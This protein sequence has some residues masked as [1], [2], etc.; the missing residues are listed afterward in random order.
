MSSSQYPLRGSGIYRNLPTFDSK[1]RGLKAIVCGA[2]GISGFHTIRALLDT[3]DRCTKVYALSPSPLSEELLSF[4]T[5]EQQARTQHVTVDLS[6]TA[7]GIAQSLRKAQVEAEY[8]FYYAYLKPKTWKSA[9]DPSL[10]E[11]LVQANL[12]P[13]ENFLDSLLLA[14]IKPL[15]KNK[16]LTLFKLNNETREW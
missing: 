5:E 10:A 6:S 15:H 14:G 13:F 9:M 3:K 8:V 1:G 11:D 16:P 12:P 2:S 4:F 7:E